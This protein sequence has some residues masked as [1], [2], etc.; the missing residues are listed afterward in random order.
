MGYCFVFTSAEFPE[1][2]ATASLGGFKKDC[3][4][5]LMNAI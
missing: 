2:R 1:S 5:E 3:Q 4:Q